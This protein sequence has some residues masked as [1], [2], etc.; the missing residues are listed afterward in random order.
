M[1]TYGNGNRNFNG[2]GQQNAGNG[3]GIASLVLGIVSFLLFCTCINWVT[4]I[5]AVIFGIVQ[6]TRHGEKAFAITGII[7]SGLSIL[8]TILLYG[9]MLAAMDTSGGSVGDFWFYGDY[10]DDG[11]EYYD[12]GYDDYDDYDDYDYYD[13]YDYYDDYD[14]E[15]DGHRFLRIRTD[16]SGI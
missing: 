1:D 11:Y 15:G 12:D 16:V 4:A 13:F 2:E 9:M 5:L 10:Y 7:T 3:F 6:L 8:M 14:L